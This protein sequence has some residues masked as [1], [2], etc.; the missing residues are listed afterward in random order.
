M[1][2]AAL[3]KHMFEPME[4]WSVGWVRTVDTHTGDGLGFPVTGKRFETVSANIAR[5]RDGKVLE[6]WSEQACSSC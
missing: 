3:L 5:L 2:D 1:A 6:H 4:I